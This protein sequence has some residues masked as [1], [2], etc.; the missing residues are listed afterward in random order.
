MR[1]SHTTQELFADVERVVVKQLSQEAGEASARAS[2]TTTTTTATKKKKKV[3]G[4]MGFVKISQRC[5][6]CNAVIDAASGDAAGR[7]PCCSSCTEA[8]EGLLLQQKAAVSACSDAAASCWAV[9]CGCVG[10][11]NDND[12]NAGEA[13]SK[14]N[15][16]ARL[17]IAYEEND[18]HTGNSSS[19]SSLTSS[20]SSVSSWRDRARACRNS[21]CANLYG[22]HLAD[23]HLRRAQRVLDRW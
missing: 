17:S 16:V 20:S 3:S 12:N 15:S 2:S 8:N 22:R 13:V 19:S 4:M 21:D 10:G 7:A 18:A 6:A 11:D 23:G 1:T 9:C 14:S 5:L